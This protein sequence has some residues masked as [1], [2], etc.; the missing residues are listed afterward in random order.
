MK[1]YVFILLLLLCIVS[2][3]ND[4]D[5]SNTNNI[6]VNL[7]I[8]NLD[9][10]DSIKNATIIVYSKNNTLKC[11]KNYVFITGRSVNIQLD[12]ISSTDKVTCSINIPQH[13]VLYYNT[14]KDFK[15]TII[16]YYNNNKNSNIM[17]GESN[18]TVVKNSYIITINL[19]SLGSGIKVSD[20]IYENKNIQ[21]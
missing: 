3:S 17:Y 5:Y 1:K 16:N 12:S 7:N 10:K 19:Y 2:C 9:T 13:K 6:I 20:F 14:L 11:I 15:T 8:N 21:F 4:D 18:V